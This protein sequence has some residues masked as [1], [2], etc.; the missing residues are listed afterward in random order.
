[1]DDRTVRLGGRYPELAA[2]MADAFLHTCKAE[3]LC[4]SLIAYI[5]PITRVGDLYLDLA[6]RAGEADSY[7]PGAAVLRRI[8]QRFL[9]NTKYAERNIPGQQRR[10]RTALKVDR[11]AATPRDIVAKTVQRGG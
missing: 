7:L 6:I 10:N 4:N 8:L 9:R 1:M 11:N 2:D 3:S 5:K